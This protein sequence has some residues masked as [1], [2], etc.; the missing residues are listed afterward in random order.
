[1][2]ERILHPLIRAWWWLTADWLLCPGCWTVTRH[3]HFPDNVWK[4][5]R[6]ARRCTVGQCYCAYPGRPRELLA[7]I[8][9]PHRERL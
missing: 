6:A 2:S 4:A 8:V 9:S 3:M 1:M 7:R 5:W